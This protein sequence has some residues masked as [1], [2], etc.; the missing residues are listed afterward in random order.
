[1]PFATV[2]QFS[3]LYLNILWQLPV[4]LYFSSNVCKQFFESHSYSGN[5]LTTGCRLSLPAQVAIEVRLQAR[6]GLK[7]VGQ[8]EHQ[9]NSCN[10]CSMYCMA[11]VVVPETSKLILDKANIPYPC[12]LYLFGRPAPP[13]FL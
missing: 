8:Q 10:Y 9:R 12:L 13:S 6:H 2:W 1:M 3:Y 11:W 7:A 4:Y 5:K